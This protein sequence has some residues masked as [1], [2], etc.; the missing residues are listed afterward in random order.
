MFS[1]LDHIGIAVRSL[2]RSLLTYRDQL[3]F[4]YEATEE[5]PTE[6]VRVAILYSGQTRIELLEATSERSPISL[7]LT[8]KGEG[9][10]H[11]AFA[12]QDVQTEVDR[13]KKVGTI[14][15][16]PAPRPGAQGCKV[17][18]IHPKSTGGILMELVERPNV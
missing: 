4:R 10:H 5:V 18:F 12:V 2:D 7:F 1:T 16:D 13:L 6:Q 17:A 8:K 14:V 9:I 11:V 15:I 3:G